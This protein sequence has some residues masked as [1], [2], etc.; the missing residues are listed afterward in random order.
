VIGLKLNGVAE[1]AKSAI[2]VVLRQVCIAA[3]DVDHVI[4]EFRE[5]KGEDRNGAIELDAPKL[6]IIWTTGFRRSGTDEFKCLTEVGDRLVIVFGLKIDQS[7]IIVSYRQVR[8]QSKC[9]IQI[10]QAVAIITLSNVDHTS[11]DICLSKRGLKFDRL[12]EVSQ[13]VIRVA[14]E[15]VG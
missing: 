11:I 9:L 14:L 4:A 7:A 3:I 1:V 8:L 10:R 6:T 15:Q 13:G 12:V 5:E 2:R